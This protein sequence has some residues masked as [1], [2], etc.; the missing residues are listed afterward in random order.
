MKPKPERISCNEQRPYHI[1]VTILQIIV[2]LI[3]KHS[4]NIEYFVLLG[5]SFPFLNC[6]IFICSFLLSTSR[7]YCTQSYINFD[8]QKGV[9]DVHLTIPTADSGFL[10]R[11]LRV[12]KFSQLAA[13]STLEH[14][15]SA[16]TKHTDWYKPGLTSSDPAVLEL[17][18]TG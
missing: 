2:G 1:S 7:V 5:L 8:F 9:C 12:R 15:W 16:R 6:F 13:R 17:I 11:F 14:Y 4:Q 10:L 3:R 18:K